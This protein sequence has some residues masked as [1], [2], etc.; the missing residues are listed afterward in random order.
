[1]STEKKDEKDDGMDALDWF[2]MA[3][4]GAE[5][6]ITLAGQIAYMIRRGQEGGEVTPQDVATAR[7]FMETERALLRAQ[8]AA[9]AANTE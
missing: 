8:V 7:A 3:T 9:D 2:A 4:R 6:A 5:A 1:M